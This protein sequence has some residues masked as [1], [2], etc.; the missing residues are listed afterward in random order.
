MCLH[1]NCPEYFWWWEA[2]HKI[3]LMWETAKITKLVLFGVK[4]SFDTTLFQ[5]DIK[6]PN[7]NTSKLEYIEQ[8][9]IVKTPT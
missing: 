4:S 6:E 2:G 1:T 9:K 8:L 5:V 3:R 7:Y